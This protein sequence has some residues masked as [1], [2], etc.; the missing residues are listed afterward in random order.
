MVEVVYHPGYAM[1]VRLLSKVHPFD[2]DRAGKAYRR[3][4]QRVGPLVRQRTLRP[5]GMVR[6]DELHLVHTPE[7]IRST[8]RY[9]VITEVTELRPNNMMQRLLLK[10][11]LPLFVRRLLLNPM[12]FATAG[13]ILASRRALETGGLVVNMAGGYHH[14][15]PESGEGFCLFSD[16]GVALASCRKA[17][18]VGPDDL[19]LYIDTDAHQGNGL[20]YVFM[21]D[22]KVKLF[23]IYNRDIYPRDPVAAGRVDCGLPIRSGT[24]DDRYM[25]LLTRNFKGYLDAVQAQGKIALAFYNAGT[26]PYVGD[27]L[28]GLGLTEDGILSRDRFVLGEL[29]HRKVP[30]VMVPSGGYSEASH[31]LLADVVAEQLEGSVA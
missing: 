22:E 5:K 13:T 8:S 21:H 14:A 23:D 18:L 19:V 25:E 30:T 9:E 7:Y 2:L 16:V 6:D 28:G 4:V 17:G 1:G 20:S 26:D 3:V 31:R 15:K 12:R 27:Q 10:G 24:S 29:R 11:L